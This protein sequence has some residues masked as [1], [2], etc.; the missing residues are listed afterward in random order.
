MPCK[1]RNLRSYGQ[2]RIRSCVA[3]FHEFNIRRYQLNYEEMKAKSSQHNTE[4]EKKNSMVFKSNSLRLMLSW[5]RKIEQ[6]KYLIFIIVAVGIIIRLVSIPIF[7]NTP[8]SPVD[9]YYA[10]NQAAKLILE[11][12]N[13]YDQAFDFQGHGFAYLPMVAVYYA[14]FYLLGDIRFGSIVADIIIMFSVYWIAKFINRGAAFFAPLTYALLPFSIWLTSVAGTNIMVGA[15]FLTLAI[16]ALLKKK[17][18]VSAT[19]LGIALA[20]NQL[21]A[22]TLPLLIYYLRGQHKLSYF[23]GSLLLCVGIILPFFITNPSGFIYD[24]GL[25]QFERNLQNDGPF[26]LYSLVKITTGLSIVSWVRI[27]LFLIVALVTVMMLRRKSSSFIPLIGGLLLVGAFVLPVNGF[28]NYFL[29]GAAFVCA[30]VPY[31]IDEVIR[32]IEPES[33]SYSPIKQT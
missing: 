28:W 25:Y 14:P 19:L 17:Y 6:T 3:Y 33:N 8:Y 15:S 20:T 21:V 11:L 27:A 18:L 22:L 5:T 10:D 9:V 1:V 23:L 29:P 7:V 4:N 31:T 16:A 24:V 13:P 30:L 32:K 26:S 2:D 12:Q